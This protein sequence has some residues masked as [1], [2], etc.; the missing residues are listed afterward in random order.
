VATGG[1][2]TMLLTT[3]GEDGPKHPTM[4]TTIC[5]IVWLECKM[6][7]HGG[8]KQSH[9]G[10]PPKTVFALSVCRITK[11]CGFRSPLFRSLVP[12]YAQYGETTMVAHQQKEANPNSDR[13]VSSGD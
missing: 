9:E 12:T 6:S 4:E 8:H 13:C 2:L 10:V 1:R 7:H 5:G 11:V 3:F